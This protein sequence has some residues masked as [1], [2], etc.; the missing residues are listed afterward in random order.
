MD[1]KEK[2]EKEILKAITAIDEMQ[3]L[4]HQLPADEG[5]DCCFLSNLVDMR[6]KLKYFL[7]K[8][9]DALA[10]QRIKE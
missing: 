6:S 10:R 2:I 7:N 1:P 8:G 4:V 3:Q 5:H 9:F